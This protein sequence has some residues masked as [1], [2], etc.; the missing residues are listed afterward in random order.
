M[1]IGECDS[2]L[3]KPFHRWCFH[4]RV[5]TERFDPIVQVVNRNHQNV[6]AFLFVTRRGRL[7]GISGLSDSVCRGIDRDQHHENR[8][9]GSNDLVH[10]V[11]QPAFFRRGFQT[12]H[13]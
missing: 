7:S 10:F 5:T 3:G 2:T 13:S 6:G 8:S 12:H 9:K 4:V 11:N 1:G